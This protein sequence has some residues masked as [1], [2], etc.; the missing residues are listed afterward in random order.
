ME[1]KGAEIL[2]DLAANAKTPKD[3]RAKAEEWLA[4]EDF[5]RVASPPLAIAG[6]L[7]AARGCQE[8][9]G[10]FGDAVTTGDRRA[11]EYL[12]ILA[13]KGGCGRRGGEDCFP[14]LR[15]DEKLGDA[16]AKIER[17]LAG[18]SKAL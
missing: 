7:R 3:I 17:R 13:V 16:I 2:Y 4:S 15:E 9:K 14:C 5:R 11:L 6:R 8:K 1:G 10:L 18:G 12:H